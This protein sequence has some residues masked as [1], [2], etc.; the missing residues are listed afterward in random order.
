MV[1]RVTTA[2]QGWSRNPTNSTKQTKQIKDL[3]AQIDKLKKT[4]KT[5]GSMGFEDD[6]EDAWQPGA[7]EATSIYNQGLGPLDPQGYLGATMANLQAMQDP[8]QNPY[9][10]NMLQTG[11][12]AVADQTMSSLGLAG[13]GPGTI[14]PV[15]GQVSDSTI[16]LINNVGDFTSDFLG[17]QYQQDMNR[18]MNAINSGMTLTPDVL[19]LQQNQPW[20]NLNNY[21]NVVSR[22][23]G[24]SPQQPN[25]PRTSGWDKLMGIGKLAIGGKTA[26][27]F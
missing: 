16:N 11:Q 20:Q 5:P 24:T 18:A 3:Q 12:E 19:Q 25:D 22:L 6:I 13:R 2:G 17:N 14:D 4:K 21:T 7:L 26:G 9:L 23:M 10:L 15:T 8:T 1:M 27:L